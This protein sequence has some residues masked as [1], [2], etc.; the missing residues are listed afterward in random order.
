MG[1]PSGRSASGL[2][3]GVLSLEQ[4]LLH[5]YFRG[6]TSILAQKDGIKPRCKI[7]N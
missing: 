4:K 2:S 3:S 6:L 7:G 5:H 1:M